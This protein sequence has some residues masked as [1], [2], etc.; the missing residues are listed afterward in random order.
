MSFMTNRVCSDLT[1]KVMEGHFGTY[2]ITGNFS[3]LTQKGDTMSFVH[4]Q[5]V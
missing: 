5:I 3:Y 4:M 2:T 1:D